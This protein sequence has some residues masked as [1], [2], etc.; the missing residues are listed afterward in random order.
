[1]CL[2]TSASVAAITAVM[3][4]S[5]TASRVVSPATIAW[6]SVGG[7]R[8]RWLIEELRVIGV[9]RWAVERLEVEGGGRTRVGDRLVGELGRGTDSSAKYKIWCILI[10]T[11]S[12]VRE[13]GG[14]VGGERREE[15]EARGERKRR[16]QRRGRGGKKPGGL[17]KIYEHWRAPVVPTLTVMSLDLQHKLLAPFMNL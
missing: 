16:R 3:T 8:D 5:T 14:R 10:N 13:G 12:S 7:W 4:T 17:T 11:F 2:Y 9:E 1:M 15:E 6:L